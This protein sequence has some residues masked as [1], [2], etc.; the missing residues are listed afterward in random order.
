MSLRISSRLRDQSGFTLIEILVVIL[1][2][3]IL[4]AIALPSF[5]N[6][7]TKA[8]DACAKSMVK[9]MFTA[10]KTFQTENGDYGGA[11]IASL[12]AI[13][14]SITANTCGSSAA[15]AIADPVAG[16]PAGACQAGTS[17]SAANARVGFCV[18]AQSNGGTWMAM[19]E[20]NGRVYRTCSVPSGQT[21]PFG[22]CKGSSGTTGTW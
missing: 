22:G 19:T 8:D 3:G 12:S 6:Q 2:I 21:L 10:T 4:T 15:I 14:Q 17:V 13:E 16:I 11:N 9:Q 20:Q 18:G 1:I 5:L 7:R